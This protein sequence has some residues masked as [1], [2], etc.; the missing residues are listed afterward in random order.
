M[1]WR[2]FH[3]IATLATPVALPVERLDGRLH[4]S[5]TP[6]TMTFAGAPETADFVAGALMTT[7]HRMRVGSLRTPLAL[8][9]DAFDTLCADGD[10]AVGEV[11]P[12]WNALLPAATELR[13]PAWVSQEI[14]ADDGSP[15]L[16]PA[17]L[18]KEVNRL[19]RR[20]R[21]TVEFS[22]DP[23]LVRRFHAELY[24]PY[25]MG[26]FGAGVILVDEA[27]FLAVSCAM[28]LAILSDGP[29]WVAGMLFRQQGTRLDLGWFGSSSVPVRPGASEVLDAR[30]I[31]RAIAGGVR[32][33]VMGHSRPSLADGVVR[34]KSRF[35]AHILPTRFPQR[36]IGLRIQRHSAALASALNAARFVV[37]RDGRPKAY[38]WP[39]AGAMP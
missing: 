17:P 6:V 11:P 35:G 15:L 5:E 4:G 37:F 34:Y 25:V 38:E 12:L 9:S 23:A 36:V 18:L 16:L 32:R 20:E 19:C 26:R 28:T 3:T 39:L 8:R 29:V 21:Y 22:T 13:M 24:R 7:T 33:V 30:V 31:E 1:A 2:H 27:R 14:H 10:F